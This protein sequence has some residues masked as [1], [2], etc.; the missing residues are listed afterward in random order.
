M[1]VVAVS[2]VLAGLVG[3][4]PLPPQ[5]PYRTPKPEEHTRLNA[6]PRELRPRTPESVTFYRTK[7]PDAE[8]VEV[9]AMTDTGENETEALEKVKQSAAGLGC[10]GVILSQTRPQETAVKPFSVVHTVETVKVA[11]SGT[12]IVFAQD[13][14]TWQ[15]APE[16][17]CVAGRRRIL[18]TTDPQQRAQI[19]REL[20]PECHQAS[21]RD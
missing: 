19:A 11:V 1:R 5:A 17:T 10:D 15:A 3:C 7:A 6:S 21:A 14:G 8:F 4:D 2:I 13:P 16:D 20:P 12:C 18:A 9:Y